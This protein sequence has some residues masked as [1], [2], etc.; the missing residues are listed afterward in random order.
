MPAFYV[1][2]FLLFL[3]DM[4]TV[5]KRKPVYNF[6]KS[7]Y[8]KERNFLRRNRPGRLEKGEEVL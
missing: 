5:K 3:C 8:N 4:Q 2:T 1:E 7:V 6:L